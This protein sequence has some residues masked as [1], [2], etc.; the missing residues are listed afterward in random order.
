MFLNEEKVESINIFKLKKNKIE[1]L[2]IL[3]K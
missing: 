1:S 2:F 3:T